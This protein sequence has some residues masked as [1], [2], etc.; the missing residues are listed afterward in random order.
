MARRAEDLL[1]DMLE[2]PEPER[3]DIV[4]EVLARLDGAPDPDW[5]AAWLAEL[6]R[7]EDSEPGEPTDD[8]EWPAVRARILSGTR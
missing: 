4:V 5:D 3:L 6:D 1:R 8:E 7:R 2:L